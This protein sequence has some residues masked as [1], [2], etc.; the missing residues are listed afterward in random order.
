MALLAYR[1]MAQPENRWEHFTLPR[2]IVRLLGSPTSLD[3]LAAE[4]HVT[5]AR[6]LWYLERLHATGRVTRREGGWERTG[7]GDELLAEPGHDDE[8]GTVLPGRSVYDYQ[9][10]FADAAAGMFGDDFVQSGGEHGAR[11]S[12][13]QARDFLERLQTLVA[14]YFAPGRGDRHGIKYGFRWVLTPADL[15]PLDD[16]HPS[17]YDG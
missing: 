3:E 14:E 17:G 4:L 13:G 5:D 1:A 9:Q 15:H 11:L 12:A 6:V 10:A 16:S 7:L 8:A 2:Q